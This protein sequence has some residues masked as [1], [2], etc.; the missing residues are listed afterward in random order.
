M[1]KSNFRVREAEQ[2][3]RHIDQERE[4]VAPELSADQAS[5]CLRG[6]CIAEEIKLKGNQLAE[7]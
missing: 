1:C 3:M 6:S 5:I 7:K 4:T 2:G